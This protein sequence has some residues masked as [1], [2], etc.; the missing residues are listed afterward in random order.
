MLTR[1]DRLGDVA[2]PVHVKRFHFQQTLSSLGA[3]ADP[4]ERMA[5]VRKSILALEK[6]EASTIDSARAAGATWG[7]IGAIYGL[8]KQGAQQRFRPAKPTAS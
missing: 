3:I 5:E 4:L 1:A 2:D 7:E 8:S 6:L